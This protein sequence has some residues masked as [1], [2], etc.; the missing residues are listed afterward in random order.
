V[1]LKACIRGGPS[2]TKGSKSLKVHRRVLFSGKMQLALARLKNETKVRKSSQYII[3]PEIFVI[4]PLFLSRSPNAD[5]FLVIH[6]SKS[7]IR[8]SLPPS[9]HAMQDAKATA[10]GCAIYAAE[11]VPSLEYNVK[12][13]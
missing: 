6:P 1:I 7:Q 13:K 3:F 2:Q 11:E 12:K 8:P 9:N 5:V 10:A 4:F